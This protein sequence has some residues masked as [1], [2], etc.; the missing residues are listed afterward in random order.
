MPRSA[1]D[2]CTLVDTGANRRTI[3]HLIPA[4]DLGR[5]LDQC[6]VR[7]CPRP[8]APTKLDPQQSVITERLAT[9]PRLTAQ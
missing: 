2:N 1:D 8:P 6:T 5:A 4:G 3:Y 7:Y 9:F